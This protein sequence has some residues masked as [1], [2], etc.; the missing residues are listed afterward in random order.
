MCT[1]T[2]WR[3]WMLSVAQP[4]TRCAAD[5]EDTVQEVLLQF[6]EV[7]RCPALGISPASVGANRLPTLDS[8]SRH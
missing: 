7:F 3:A 8:L 4:L 5:A 1:E 6:W 2:E